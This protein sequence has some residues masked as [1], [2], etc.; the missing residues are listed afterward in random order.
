M[1]TKVVGQK[2]EKQCQDCKWWLER[3]KG[4]TACFPRTAGYVFSPINETA[5]PTHEA[6]FNNCPHHWEV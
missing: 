6:T 5:M 4:S 1:P 3:R 2:Y